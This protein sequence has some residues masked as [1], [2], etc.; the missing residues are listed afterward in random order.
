[1]PSI[2]PRYNPKKRTTES[3]DQMLRRFK[4]ACDNAGIVQE[5]RDRQY[6]EK[7]NQKKHKKNQAQTRRNKLDA[8]KRDKAGRPKRWI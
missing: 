3:F 5:V 1:M 2:T 6:F 7:P 8:I 4:K